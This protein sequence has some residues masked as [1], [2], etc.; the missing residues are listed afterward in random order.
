MYKKLRKF[1]L[2]KKNFQKLKRSDNSPFIA[3]FR[4]IS[5]Q[6]TANRQVANSKGI[7]R[8]LAYFFIFYL[9]K[10]Y[11]ILFCLRKMRHNAPQSATSL[12]GAMWRDKAPQ[13]AMWRKKW[14]INNRYVRNRTIT[15][16]SIL[17]KIF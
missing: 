3:T 10:L 14:Q 13:F 6:I 5:S 8:I 15:S 11:Q 4:H 1:W 12:Y 16:T 9:I 17:I 2:K 7:W